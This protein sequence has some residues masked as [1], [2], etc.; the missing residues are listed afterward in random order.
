MFEKRSWK[1]SFPRSNYDQINPNPNPSRVKN[2]QK[3]T[4]GRCPPGNITSVMLLQANM[5]CAHAK[6]LTSMC[7]LPGEIKITD[8][9]KINIV[10]DI[11]TANR[12]PT[13]K[14]EY[15][16]RAKKEEREI[17]NRLSYNIAASRRDKPQCRV[18]RT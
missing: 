6:G 8:D 3:I 11:T 2:C 14:R 12:L 1:A 5:P 18:T 16:E 10:S 15:H 13:G 4:R 9:Y 17:N 7:L